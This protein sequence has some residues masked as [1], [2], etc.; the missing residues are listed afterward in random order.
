MANIAR[1]VVESSDKTNIS[2]YFSRDL[3]LEER[4]NDR[5]VEYMLKETKAARLA[6]ELSL[7]PLDDTLCEHVGSLFEYVDRHYN[8]GDQTYPL[9]HNPQKRK[10]HYLAL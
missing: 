4:V 1:C 9:A 7:L 3:W 8:H 2:R 6:K 10:S 5:R